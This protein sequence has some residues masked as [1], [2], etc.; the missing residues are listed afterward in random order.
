MT[1]PAITTPLDRFTEIG[2]L[3]TKVRGTIKRVIAPLAILLAVETGY[4][5][6]SG[7][8]GA[9]AFGMI[10]LGT[11]IALLGWSQSAIGLPLLPMMAVQSLVIYGVPIVAGH[12]N[13][14]TYPANFVL[15]AGIEVLL[16]NVAMV[17][18]WAAGMQ[19]FH[20]SRPVSYA[21][22]EFNRTGAQGWSRLGFI[23]VIV[24]TGTQLVEGFDFGNAIVASLPTGSSSILYA[25]L[26]VAS[27]CG[28]FLI[29][30]VV[31][32]NEV[33]VVGKMAFW[34]LL[35]INGM[36]MASGFLLYSAAA[37]LITVA[38]GFFWSN[39]RIPWRYLAAVMLMLS[40]LNSGKYAM[41]TRYWASDDSLGLQVSP[42][43]LPAVYTEWVDSSI[44]AYLETDNPSP[45]STL[46]STG[47]K[48][49]SQTLLDR[50]DNLQNLLFIIDAIKVGHAKPLE[51]ATYTLIPPLLI[52]RILWPDKPR[53]HEGQIL[54][55]VHFGRQDLYSTY[56]TYVAWGLLPEAYANFGSFVGS[57]C[58]GSVL[59][60]LFAWVE[61]LS[62]RKLV[63][64]LEGFLALN[65]LMSLM[66][67][68][69]MVA[70]VLVTSTF[71]SMMVVIGACLPFVHR[72][73]TPRREIGGP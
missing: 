38:I 33:S 7:H 73:V 37:S 1:T 54:L 63:V 8:A 21:L 22:Q 13:I 52:P 45:L 25:L 20:P 23:L 59:G 40:F 9:V 60:L 55:N 14:M 6:F 12:E 39:G 66:N 62:A 71:Q 17:L 72:T 27:A 43:Q 50:V 28:F 67:S 30:L 31:G 26:S 47:P 49:R 10:A 65:L 5:N 57:I 3:S 42:M 58:I 41:R 69:E 56:T 16:F 53:T 70:S 61:N 32:G 51:G 4:L 29:S 24:E 46:E 36:I 44:D 19:L 35:V 34:V 11:C 18:A 2:E 48:K 64:S 15:Q 68:F